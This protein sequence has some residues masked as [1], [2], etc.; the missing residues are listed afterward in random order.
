MSWSVLSLSTADTAR[1][2]AVLTYSES[3]QNRGIIPLP[4]D[5]PV[6]ENV[7][8]TKPDSDS[9]VLSEICEFNI[10][11]GYAIMHLFKYKYK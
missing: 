8:N 10:L 9:L 3:N 1:L 2:L 4:Q 6:L 5:M 11:F 7:S